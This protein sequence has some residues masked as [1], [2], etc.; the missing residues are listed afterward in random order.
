M[1]A[2][3]LR[4][5]WTL[6]W[7]RIKAGLEI[8]HAAVTL[9][10]MTRPLQRLTQVGGI[11]LQYLLLGLLFL[12]PAWIVL[13]RLPAVVRLLQRDPL[14][15]FLIALVPLSALWSISPTRT[16]AGSANLLVGTFV[17]IYLAIRFPL[18]KQV[19]IVALAL[20][21]ALLSSLLVSLVF[22]TLGRGVARGTVEVWSGVYLHKNGLGRY[23]AIGAAAFWTLRF[24]RTWRP[25]LWL[26]FGLAIVLIL[27]ANSA[28]SL[29]TVVLIIGLLPLYR[30][31]RA[32][33]QITRWTSTVLLVAVFIAVAFVLLHPAFER[34]TDYVLLQL[35][36]RPDQN[37]L[38]V[39]L[40]LWDY[41]SAYI[42]GRPWLG[43]GFDAF[44]QNG[45][46]VHIVTT[47]RDWLVFQA[48]NGYLELWLQL[49]LVGLSG[50]VLHLVLNFRRTVRVARHM[51]RV[52]SMWCFSY[53]TIM[54]VFNFTYSA[55]LGQL[56]V[57]WTLYVAL[58]LSLWRQLADVQAGADELTA[59]PNREK[60]LVESYG[61]Q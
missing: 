8:A 32:R 26:L 47:N 51:A 44:W 33:D 24:E 14:L 23:M 49:G 25:V 61:N 38:L 55:L 53:L 2:H 48:H 34:L 5:R 3:S 16:L 29:M 31:L 37:S 42:A 45:R 35:G 36:R 43:Y 12:Y 15:V 46:I 22:P 40:A 52:E 7:S 60:R 56:T 6:D 9:F 58:T 20:G 4:I 1:A 28:T 59:R 10:I 30:L 18:R 11:D 19:W 50:M 54:T 17:G 21:M 27:L 57:P 41:V 13:A 39:R